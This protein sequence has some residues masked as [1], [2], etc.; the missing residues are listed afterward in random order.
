[1]EHKRG[2]NFFFTS[3][4]LHPLPLLSGGLKGK[5][6]GGSPGKNGRFMQAADHKSK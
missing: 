5:G 2:G 6:V 3:V 1:M 4:F